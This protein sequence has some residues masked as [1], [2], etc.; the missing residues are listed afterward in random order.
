MTSPG[1]VT[2]FSWKKHIAEKHWIP[3]G[4]QLYITI[5]SPLNP[6]KSPSITMKN[7]SFWL[8]KSPWNPMISLW[9]HIFFG[10]NHPWNAP[11]C[12]GIW[13]P[14]V[15]LGAS[16][17][18]LNWR[19]EHCLGPGTSAGSQWTWRTRVGQRDSSRFLPDSLLRIELRFLGGLKAQ[20]PQKHHHRLIWLLRLVTTTANRRK[21]EQ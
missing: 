15:P 3:S 1:S 18:F 17:G 7:H 21:T 12:H 19:T 10:L 4:H 14:L 5:K 13:P 2:Q 20:R 6:T 9:N 8:V 16:S 11:F